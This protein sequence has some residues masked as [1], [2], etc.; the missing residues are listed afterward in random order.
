MAL[1]STLLSGVWIV[2][3]T[4]DIWLLLCAAQ[5]EL[6]H[7]KGAFIATQLNSTRRRVELSCVAINGPLHFVD[8]GRW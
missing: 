8:F 4:A 5:R 2:L 3:A 6:L 7:N 1:H